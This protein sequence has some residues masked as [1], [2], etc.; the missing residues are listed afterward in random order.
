MGNFKLVTYAYEEPRIDSRELAKAL[1]IEHSSLVKTIIEFYDKFEKTSCLKRGYEK[2]QRTIF[3]LLTEDQ[4]IFAAVLEKADPVI[5]TNIA[6]TFA[7]YQEQKEA[8]KVLTHLETALQLYSALET[9]LE[10][11]KQ[12]CYALQEIEEIK[13]V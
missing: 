2:I 4:T 10:T 11:A 12:L 9:Q 1:N 3:Y 8:A 5:H 7:D 13:E 6:K